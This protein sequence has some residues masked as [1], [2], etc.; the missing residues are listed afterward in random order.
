M[1]A[2]INYK[3]K[4]MALRAK[5]MN[6]LDVA[7]RLGMEQGAQQEQQNQMAEQQ[8]QQ[9]AMDQAAM[10]G[11]DGQPGEGGGFGGPQEGGDQPPG[12]PGEG[13]PAEGGNP[14]MAAQGGSEL[15]QHISQLEGLIAKSES[16]SKDPDIKKSLDNLKA[17]RK[18]ELFK[19]EMRK[20]DMA[21]KG[22][23]EA[24]H[25]PKFKFGVQASHNMNSNAKQAVSLQHKIVNDVLAKMQE[26]E[27]RASSDIKNILSIEGL[28][29]K[30]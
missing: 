22:I 23:A 24:L 17:M 12:Q 6:D 16:L 26:E 1:S 25:K 3:N 20:S 14:A 5:Y 9:Q 27:G 29:K 2:E 10:A 7:F 19:I 15:D 4:Y 13:A 11:Q 21:V 8:A 18:N 30:E 28:T